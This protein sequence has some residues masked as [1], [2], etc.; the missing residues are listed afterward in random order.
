[1][2]KKLSDS[3]SNF[4][5]TI[6]SSSFDYPSNDLDDTP[7]RISPNRFLE[8]DEKKK[9]EKERDRDREEDYGGKDKFDSFLSYADDVIG[10]TS[11]LEIEDFDGYLSDY[12]MDDEDEEIRRSLIKYGRKYARENKSTGESSEVNKAYAK[13]EEA[14]ANLIEEVAADKEDIQ[15]DITSMRMSRTRNYKT[16]AELIEAKTTLHNT[17]LSALK[18]INSITKSKFDIS[19][20]QKKETEADGDSTVANRMIQNLFSMGRDNLVGSYADMSGSAEA[21]MDYDV[22]GFDEA[23]AVRDR[24]IGEDDGPETEGDKFLKYENVFSKYVLEYDK[25]KERPIQ[26][27]AEDIEGNPIPDYPVPNVNDL[28]FDYS[29]NTGTATDNLA[30]QYEL[31]VYDDDDV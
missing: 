30:Q 28:N 29:F 21:G 6:P 22:E 17:Q 15:K 25:T 20:K 27:I 3:L 26:I 14:L 11:D 1:M 2:S 10:D 13:A 16:F 24:Y 7:E 5:S 4:M 31:R 19:L 12:L 9:K 18:E 8:Y 23:D